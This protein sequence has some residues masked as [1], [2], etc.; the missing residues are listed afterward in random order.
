MSDP[1]TCKVPIGDFVNVW[2]TVTKVR[3]HISST[4]DSNDGAWVDLVDRTSNPMQIDLLNIAETTC[5]LATL[6][7]TSGL[8]PGS[9]QQ[10]R[11]HLLS[12]SPGN[13][14]A[15]PSTNNC[16]AAGFNCVVLPG[17]IKQVLQ[18]S[19]QD[20][21]GIK[22]PPGR[23]AGGAISIEAGQTSD[24]NIDFSACA[25]VVRQG[26]GQ[27]RLN[28][29][30]HAGEVSLSTDSISGRVIDNATGQPIPGATIFVFAEQ[31]DAN[32]ATI[33]RV[34]MS[35]TADS[36][37]GTF[38]FCPLPSGNYDIVV[39][40]VSDAGVTYNAT[41]TFGVPTGTALADIPLEP[42]TGADT[43]SAQIQ[44]RVSTTVDGTTATGADIAMS[45]FQSGGSAMQV[46]IPLLPG[47]SNTFATEALPTCSA[48]TNCNDYVLF[49]PGSNPMV[50]TFTTSG[51]VYAPVTGDILYSVNAQAFVPGGEGTANCSP[52]TVTTSLNDAASPLAVTVGTPVT[53]ETLAFTGCTSGF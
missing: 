23:I 50:G 30:L 18:L 28:P 3:A 38:S 10:I 43:T 13:G 24:I 48:E 21:T 31:P 25:S 4:A 5:A 29:T 36:T 47:P 35:R 1:P 14:V 9:Y 19:S 17:D 16:G 26:N 44:G 52:S 33:D 20:Q 53:A 51:T 7:S 49:V 42:E 39:A 6:G 46:T 40:A 2:V 27:F 45:A 22:I 8:P 41:I 12:N 32:D 34:I 15:V 11:L 37:A